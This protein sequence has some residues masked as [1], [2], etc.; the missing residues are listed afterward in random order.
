MN[1]SQPLTAAVWYDN[2]SINQF[3]LEASDLITFH[4]YNAAADLERQIEALKIYGRP[5]VCSEYMLRGRGSRFKT[6]LPIF[7]R[8]KVGCMNWGLVSGKTQTIF[9]WGEPLDTPEPALWF[10]DILRRDG[11]A[12]DAAE[13][14]FIRKIL[15]NQA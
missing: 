1:P 14:T 6:H 15:K 10:H 3:L 2:P 8:E 13:A 9:A 11:T 4:N 12:F 7:K 5:L